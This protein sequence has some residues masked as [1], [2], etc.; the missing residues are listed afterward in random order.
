MA[1]FMHV[2]PVFVPVKVFDKPITAAKNIRLQRR[3]AVASRNG[4]CFSRATAFWRNEIG[5]RKREDQKVEVQ[6]VLELPLHA[7]FYHKHRNGL[8]NTKLFYSDRY[9]R[10]INLLITFVDC[11]CTIPSSVYSVANASHRI[12]FRRLIDVF[13]SVSLVCKRLVLKM[14]FFKRSLNYISTRL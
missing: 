11:N 8:F 2:Q 13:L 6:F 12:A 10:L 3:E 1:I 14:V 5:D 9:L 4:N 7:F